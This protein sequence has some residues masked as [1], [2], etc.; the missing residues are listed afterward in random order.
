MEHK[1]TSHRVDGSQSAEHRREFEASA[2]AVQSAHTD[3]AL[4]A[5]WMGPAGTTVDLEHFDA[6]TGG[7]YRYV[8]RAGE[9]GAWAFRGSYHEVSPGR[10]VHTWEY[11]DEPGVTLEILT[12]TDLPGGRSALEIRST[13]TSKEAL[14]ALVASGMDTGMD[15]NFER[16]DA[17]LAR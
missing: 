10:I 9:H 14:A 16:L 5:Q 13:Y 4:F 7:S 6:T 3:P 17:L 2:A 15:E 8:V 12:F 1:Q 11:L